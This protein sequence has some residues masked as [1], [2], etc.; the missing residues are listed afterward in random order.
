MLFDPLG[1]LGEMLVL[2]SKVVLFAEIDEVDDRFG[3][4]E[5]EWIDDFNLKMPSYLAA[6]LLKC[7]RSVTMYV[8]SW[9]QGWVLSQCGLSVIY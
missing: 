6:S 7:A 5:E 3:C 8:R 2:L 9:S 4:K 1:D